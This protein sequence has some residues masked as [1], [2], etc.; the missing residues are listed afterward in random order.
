MSTSFALPLETPRYIFKGRWIYVL[1]IG[2]EK[3]NR[4]QLR[5]IERVSL[6]D[7]PRGTVAKP[8]A[9][10]VVAIAYYEVLANLWPTS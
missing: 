7:K 9:E 6:P 5:S 10:F 2:S 8:A 1:W 3:L 4:D